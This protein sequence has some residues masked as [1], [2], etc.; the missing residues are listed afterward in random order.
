LSTTMAD[1]L[2]IFTDI[3]LSESK[4]FKPSTRIAH[5][6]RTGRWLS[7]FMATWHPSLDIF[8]VGSM[9]R[10]REIQVFDSSENMR[11]IVGDDLTAVA[12]RCCFHARTDQLTVVGGNSSGRVNVVR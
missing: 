11:N 2:D 9:R 10:P 6:N 4:T 8:C 3:H 7:T 5:D 12:S 1:K